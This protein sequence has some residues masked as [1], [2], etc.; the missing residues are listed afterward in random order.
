[1][2]KPDGEVGSLIERVKIRPMRVED[3]DAVLAIEEQAFPTPWS[4]RAFYTEITENNLAHYVVVEL[5]GIVVAYSG[6]WVIL[7][8]AHMTN[9]AVHPL[10]RRM[11]IGSLLL[12]EMLNRARNLGASRM[13]LEV[14]VSNAPAQ[15]LYERFGF[16]KRGLR[17]RYYTDTQE[18]AIIMWRDDLWGKNL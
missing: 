4:R 13:T 15:R 10:Y 9:I 12:Q 14:R 11:G 5:D 3:I 6:M 8:E 16:V 18:D 7:D 1:M 2:S 17:R